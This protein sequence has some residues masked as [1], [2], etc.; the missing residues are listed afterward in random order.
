M[1]T[2]LNTKPPTDK[3]NGT[4]AKSKETVNST[5]YN[6]QTMKEK[7]KLSS[8]SATVNEARSTV[9]SAISHNPVLLNL[10]GG[11]KD[12][13]KQK[14]TEKEKRDALFTRNC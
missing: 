13:Q 12:E 1:N 14:Q 7:K 6:S 9:Q 11:R 5:N 4:T 3:C 2:S 10:F 8:S